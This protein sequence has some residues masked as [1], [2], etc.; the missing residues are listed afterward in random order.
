MKPLVTLLLAFLLSG[1]L[2]GLSQASVVIMGTRVILPAERGQ[3][4][5]RMT[6]NGQ[7]P[8]LVEAWIDA[9]NAKAT[10][11]SVHTPFLITP[12]LFRLDQGRDQSLRILFLPDQQ[13][14]HK[15]AKPFSG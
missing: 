11:N 9:G 12:P 6:N 14:C 5:V 7:L 2:P 1:L 4:T 15:I 10:P 3:T 8:A 13:A